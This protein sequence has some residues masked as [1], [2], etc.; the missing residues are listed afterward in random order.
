MKIKV[1]K[2]NGN[3]V[4]FNEEKI[5]NAITKGF[6]DYGEITEE[7]KIFI[8]DVIKDIQIE[9]QKYTDG[10]EVEEIQDIIVAKMRKAGFRKVAKGYQEY[11]EKRAKARELSNVL[12]IL[13]N[14]AT[15]EKN[16]NANVNGYTPSGRH[17]HISEDVIK[18]YMKNYFFSKDV[19]EA[20]NAGI[21]YPH[22]L[23]WGTTTMT[24]VQIDLP[25]LFK[26]GFST[27]HG[28][29]REPS[30]IK[31]A[32]LQSAIAIQSNQNDMWGG[33]SIPNYDYALAPY[34][35]KTFKKHLKKL[36]AYEDAK[37]HESA[38][39]ALESLLKQVDEI[40]SIEDVIPGYEYICKTAYAYTKEDTFQGAESLVHNLNSMAS[41][42]GSQVP[43]SSLNFGIDTSPEG[44]MVSEY[45]LKAQ[46]AGLGKHET[47]IFPILIYTLKKGV[48]FEK[49]DPNYDIFRLA[50]ECSSK[51]L[52]PTYAFVDASFNLPYYERDPYY[53]IIN[54]MGCRTRVMANV[55]GR[56]GAFGRGNISFTSINLPLLALRAK[57]N[58]DKFFKELDYALEIADKELL[59]RYEGQCQNRKYNFPSLMEQGIWLGSDD[60]APTDEIRDVVKQGTLSIGFV[61]LAECLIALTGKHHGESQESDELGYSIIKYIRDY[62]DKR[63][64][65]T[66]LNFSC[67]GTPAET[68]CKTALEQA[69]KQFGIIP[70]VTD[71]AY[72]TNSS[73]IPVWYNISIADKAKIEGKYHNLEN[74]GHIFY[75]EV[76]GDI[77]KNIDAF[78]NIL[79]IM[80]DADVGY[81]AV[82]IGVVECTVCGYS[83]RDGS[84][85]HI[86][87]NCGRDER[88]PIDE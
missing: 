23:G 35:L 33:Q 71:R 17:L 37:K 64:K 49:G 55:N 58:V 86:C 1:I 2:R 46:M 65:E 30:N 66:H 67:L 54:T 56:E 63:V 82:N 28:Y 29:L 18:S 4:D 22:D 27:G 38:S 77:S 69:R 12:D 13:S 43:F 76:D 19:T 40:K 52:F 31:T 78:E 61:G 57:G 68:Y 84:D 44:R 7:K 59:E 24:C 87:P 51:R 15:E 45:L 74:A 10:I 3:V 72:F 16:D 60:L 88:E 79:H 48:N 36:L 32:F 34:V 70:G 9:A 81:G 53:G 11:R 6:L 5:R 8:K 41:R 21:I 25:K 62:C 14:E 39:I 20:I 47:P 42:A 85:N 26:D 75:C 73:H 50:M 83:W 80:S